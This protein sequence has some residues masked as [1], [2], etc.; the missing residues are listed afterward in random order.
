MLSLTKR[1]VNQFVECMLKFLPKTVTIVLANS[2]Q[3]VFITKEEL[4]A[5]DQLKD[6]FPLLQIDLTTD[7]TTNQPRYSN[8]P[9]EIS[10]VV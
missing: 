5:D 8:T 6:P 1:S 10:L 9:A 7:V 3:N 2:V 4:E